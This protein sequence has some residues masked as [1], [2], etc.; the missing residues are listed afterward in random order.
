GGRLSV[1]GDF[2]FTP[3]FFGQ[4]THAFSASFLRPVPGR[5]F[6]RRRTFPSQ[7]ES[8]H[9]PRARAP[10][11]LVSSLSFSPAFLRPV[12]PRLRGRR[13]RPIRETPSAR[14]RFC[15]GLVL[16]S[17]CNRQCAQLRVAQ[18][19]RTTFPPRPS[20][21]PSQTPSAVRGSIL[22]CRA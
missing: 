4:T 21:V 8:L 7:R 15:A 9:L 3:S 14:N 11:L 20:G 5:P 19:R 13:R 1:I 10:R 6:L 12:F 18:C 17:G 22:S 16:R 2:E